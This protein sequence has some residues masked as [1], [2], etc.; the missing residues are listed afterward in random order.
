MIK[1]KKFSIYAGPCSI[2]NNKKEILEIAKIEINGKMAIT[3][4]RIVGLKSRTVLDKSGEGMGMDY[5]TLMYNFQ[6][7][8]KG[9]N[10]KD[11]QIPPS[12]EIAKEIIKKTGL[13]IATEIMMP[14]V[15]LPVLSRELPKQKVMIWNP[16]VNQLGWQV[17][18]MSAVAKENEWV[19]GLKNGKWVGEH[20]EVAD[21]YKNSELKTPIESAWEGLV[22]LIIRIT[23]Y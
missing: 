14:I 2:D 10:I 3:G 1:N 6:L 15:Q 9:G 18:Q 4:T 21:N 23:R 16:S 22:T 19:V 20:I 8:P 12:I 7:L 13:N 5:E 17:M 11:F